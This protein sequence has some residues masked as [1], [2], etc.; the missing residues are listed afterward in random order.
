MPSNTTLNGIESKDSDRSLSI[1]IV[2]SIHPDFDARIWRHAR[3]LATAGHTVHLICPWDVEAGSVRDGVIFHPFKK[4]S[5]RFSRLF[6]IPVRLFPALLKIIG[7][8]DIVHFHDID[9]LPGM[10]IL[11]LFKPVVYDVHENYAEEMLIR[12]SVPRLIRRPLSFAVRW[13]QWFFSRIIRNVVLVAPS[14]DADFKS[15]WLKRIYLYNFASRALIDT[16][17]SDYLNRDPVV[18]FTGSHNENNG[19]M[20]LLEIVEGVQK[21]NEKIKFLTTD[22][23]FE[24]NFKK[25]FLEE[26]NK[27]RLN[28]VVQLIPSVRPHELMKILNKATIAISPNLRVSQ[29]IMGIHTKIFEYM[30]AGLPMILSDLPHQVSIIKE[31]DAGILASP[32][33]PDEFVGAILRLTEDSSYAKEAGTRGQRAYLERY[34]YESQLDTLLSFYRRVLNIKTL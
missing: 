17:A 16:V 18:V 9:L 25:I 32:E 31:A 34:C 26:I 19:S 7:K 28:E 1:A 12:Q 23:F 13:G 33:R 29:Q 14:Q 8:V 15:S 4:S 6:H 11:S 27:R 21:H 20:L 10:A 5:S 2:T 22:R 24:S 3:L 30:A